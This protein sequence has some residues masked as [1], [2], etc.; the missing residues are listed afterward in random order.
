[1]HAVT[2]VSGSGPAYYFYFMEAMIAAGVA[3]GLSAEQS[4]ALTLQTAL[5]AATLAQTSEFEPGE[6]KR[7]VMSPGG[8]TEQAIRV[9][10]S[11]SL[12]AII[13]QGM[14]ACA[15]RSTILAQELGQSTSE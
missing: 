9:F 6:L 10:E 11:E 1:M 5:G 3:Q 14:A 13:A 7:R 15:K 4:R 2:A 12:D 8:T